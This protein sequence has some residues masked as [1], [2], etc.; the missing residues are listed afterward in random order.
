MTLATAIF[1][2][3]T[4]LRPLIKAVLA[5]TALRV[6]WIAINLWHPD[7]LSLAWALVPWPRW[8]YSW[9]VWAAE[10]A[11]IFFQLRA[12]LRLGRL[13]LVRYAPDLAAFLGFSARAAGGR[14]HLTPRNRSWLPTALQLSGIL[15]LSC[16]VLSWLAVIVWFSQWGPFDYFMWSPYADRPIQVGVGLSLLGL[17]FGGRYIA[18]ASG[19]VR[20]SFG[21][22]SVEDGHWLAERV[23]GLAEKL[24]LP[25][26]AV[27]ITNVVNAFAMGA[28]QKSSMVV[29]GKPLFA[30]EK[31]ELDA[32]IGHELGHILHKDIA[33]MQFAEGF[34]RML[35]GVVN[36]LTVFGMFFAASASRKRANGRLNAHLAWG[37]GVVVRK[38]VFIGSELVTKG[39]SRNRE[40]HAD[41]VGAHVTSVDAMARA[42]TRLHGM[43]DEPTAQEHHYGYLM[44]RG[45]GFGNLF[46]THPTLQARLKALNARAI[47]QQ[48]AAKPT[49]DLATVAGPEGAQGLG[50]VG[51]SGVAPA[52]V[53]A[54]LGAITSGLTRW[55]QHRAAALR[56]KVS[57]RRL[58]IVGAACVALAVVAPAIVNF[59]ALDRRFDDTRVSAGHAL[60]SSWGWVIA[61]KDAWFGDAGYAERVRQLDAREQAVKVAE[62]ALTA[63]PETARTRVVAPSV[64]SATL[65]AAITDRDKARAEAKDL[66]Q[67]LDAANVERSARLAVATQPDAQRQLET[68]SDQLAKMTADR[69]EMTHRND[70]LRD[71]NLELKGQIATRDTARV[72][73]DKQI[74][75]LQNQIASLTTRPSEDPA[76]TELP[77]VRPTPPGR[78]GGYGAFAVA[79]NGIVILT[80]RSFASEQEAADAA[81]AECGQFSGGS[82]CAVRQTFRNTCAAVARVIPATKRS[83]Y[84]LQLEPTIDDAEEMAL[85]ECF[86]RNGR[87]C[88]VTR[89][90]CVR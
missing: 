59:Y 6:G 82:Q 52:P 77:V 63:D 51:A 10:L 41:A 17:L 39:I 9:T 84:E 33:R 45:T 78:Q 13:L 76:Q 61:T 12:G 18:R 21:V 8:T 27:G 38:T 58:L 67:K 86:Q 30:L 79:G 80:D 35:V 25:K 11:L 65:P 66:Q 62:A 37:T 42:L 5:V 60:S 19:D 20:S 2:T 50:L 7:V 26:P 88:E 15:V 1:G 70:V 55:T 36:I 72:G 29:I 56:A 14:Q 32:I 44:F 22:T 24:N 4:R 90:V 81:L 64:D 89:Q 75:D 28:R 47:A 53:W 54:K 85:S 16:C 23:H 83:R 34:Q 31:D 69:D 68:V 49:G 87:P 3:E 46:S 73:L 74:E 40:F 43:G 71:M 48:A 57:T